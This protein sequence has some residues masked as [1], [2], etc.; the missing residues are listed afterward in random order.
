VL[1][2][3]VTDQAAAGKRDCEHYRQKGC[4]GCKNRQKAL[5]RD[6]GALE[7][8]TERRSVNAPALATWQIL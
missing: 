2:E 1:E 4:Y 5:L 7:K 3:K 6:S 8:P